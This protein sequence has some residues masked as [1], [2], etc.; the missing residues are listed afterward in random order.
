MAEL[1]QHDSGGARAVRRVIWITLLLNVLVAALKIAY[2]HYASALSI[3]ADGFHSLTDSANNLVGLVGVTVASRPADSGHPYGHHKFEILA[4][5][6]VGLSLLGM[7]YDVADS[8]V[9]RMTSAAADL[10][11]IDALA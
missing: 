9:E 2:G 6:L 8:A 3:R 4:A 11:N 7:A 10:P 5:G 1:R